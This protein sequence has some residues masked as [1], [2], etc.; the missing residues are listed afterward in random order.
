MVSRPSYLSHGGLPPALRSK[1][2]ELG[3]ETPQH[4]REMINISRQAMERFLGSDG[5]GVVERWLATVSVEP[6]IDRQ[7]WHPPPPGVPLDPSPREA[8]TSRV[9]TA[10]RDE[11]FERLKTL[12]RTNAPAARIRALEEELDRFL[13]SGSS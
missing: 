6:P 8:V 1:L 4:L 5:L 7:S 13:A 2:A 10:R 12:R 3:A 9:D 11:L